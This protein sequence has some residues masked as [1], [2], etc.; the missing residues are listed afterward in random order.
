MVP[1]ILMA[2]TS[3]RGLLWYKLSG[4]AGGGFGVHLMLLLLHVQMAQQYL[5]ILLLPL[6]LSL[7]A[8]RY[9]GHS[10]LQ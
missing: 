1:Q 5:V 10:W 2:G 7:P 8:A 3:F 9:L 4:T 6:W